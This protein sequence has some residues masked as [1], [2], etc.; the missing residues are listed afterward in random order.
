MRNTLEA[1]SKFGIQNFVFHLNDCNPLNVARNIMILKIISES[2]FNPEDQ[3][4]LNF[5][6]DVW[7]NAKWPEHT[8]SRFMVVLKELLDNQLPENATVAVTNGDLLKLR[9]IW[10][11][12]YLTCSKNGIELNML[13]NDNSKERYIYNLYKYFVFK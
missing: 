7:Y 11:S 13:M 12:W 9:N 5:L 10:A 4:D 2:K 1:T 8:R 3:A 6:W